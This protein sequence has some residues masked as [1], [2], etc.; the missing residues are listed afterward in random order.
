MMY[1]KIIFLSHHE[2]PQSVS[3]M[4]TIIKAN[5][6]KE[7]KLSGLRYTLWHPCKEAAP[8]TECAKVMF[9]LTTI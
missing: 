4:V 6:T 2:M 1:Y 5:H 9:V 7:R 8:K 3:L